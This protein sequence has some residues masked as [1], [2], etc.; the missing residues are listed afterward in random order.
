[1]KRTPVGIAHNSHIFPGSLR[2]HVD[3]VSGLGSSDERWVG[4]VTQ[5]Q[6]NEAFFVMCV[7]LFGCSLEVRCAGKRS[8]LREEM[9]EVEHIDRLAI[10]G[11]RP[12]AETS[13]KCLNRPLRQR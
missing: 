1:Q 7:G 11:L 12:W 4:G 5:P 3:Q 6:P 10:V 8:Y 13:N 9:D 2:L